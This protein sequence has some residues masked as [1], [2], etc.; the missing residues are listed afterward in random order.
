MFSI[1]A[2]SAP[3]ALAT[4][5]PTAVGELVVD[6]A[7]SIFA[8]DLSHWRVVDYERQ[9]REGVT[10]LLRGA[11][12]SALMSAY[13]GP[14]GDAHL[15]WALWRE[16]AELYVQPHCVAASDLEKPFDLTLAYDH[17]DVRVPARDQALPI[18]E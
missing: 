16:N 3:A 15:M 18:T 11:P 6:G 4:D 9:W 10:R 5:V 8:L 2:L 1:R 13:R 14:H 7:R 12:S 17:V